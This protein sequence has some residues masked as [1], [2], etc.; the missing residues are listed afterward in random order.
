MLNLQTTALYRKDRKRAIKRGL[1]IE[2]FDEVLQTL[3]EEKPLDPKHR[4]HELVGIYA[5][6]REWLLVYCFRSFYFIFIHFPLYLQW[7]LFT[8]LLFP[9]T[10]RF[11]Q[12]T[13]NV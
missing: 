8:C 3:I 1:P 10:L 6:L 7:F 13:E 5:G 9:F 2:L 11:V 12:F 4:D